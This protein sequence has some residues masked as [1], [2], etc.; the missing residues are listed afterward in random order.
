MARN[1]HLPLVELARDLNLEVAF[2]RQLSRVVTRNLA[3][4]NYYGVAA[5]PNRFLPNG[6]LKPAD[7]Q[8][9][10]DVSPDYRPAST[11]VNQGRLTL[12]YERSVRDW[13]TL[14]LAGLG[15]LGST[16]SRSEIFQQYWLKGSSLASGGAFNITPENSANTVYYRY[17]LKDLSVLND[18]NFRI[19]GP[20]D[21]SGATKSSLVSVRSILCSPWP[22]L[23]SEERRVGKECRSRWSPYH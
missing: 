15:E 12:S 16:K 17:Y 9:Y 11:S 19:P 14:R 6:Q 21:L 18:P 3:T 8:Y 4:W 22:R 20:Y 23:R 13:A 1:N 5:D 7:M 2:N 10:F